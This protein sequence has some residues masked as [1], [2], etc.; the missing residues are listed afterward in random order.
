MTKKELY[1]AIVNVYLETGQGTSG[2][3]IKMK[4]QLRIPM[5]SLIDDGLI[6][7]V[8]IRFNHLPNDD[9]YC[10][11]D[12]YCVEEDEDPGAL[13]YIRYYLGHNDMG[14]NVTRSQVEGSSDFMTGYRNWLQKHK[15]E[16][17]NSF[18]RKNVEVS[19]MTLNEEEINFLK[20]KS[21]Y[22]ENK[23]IGDCISRNREGEST[24]RELI[25]LY[26]RLISLEKISSK[27]SKKNED[28]LEKVEKNLRIRDKINYF[29]SSH[30]E[31]S[32]IQ[33]VI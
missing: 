26:N 31:M 13:S 14:L 11:T 1:D 6:K 22:T 17:R 10:L 4:S 7:K 3:I 27:D 24:D 5:Q 9:F 19:D 25:G 30:D 18:D 15:E 21:W 23:T 2:I 20:S 33:D 8:D 12:R 28:E 29:L 16:L 32:N